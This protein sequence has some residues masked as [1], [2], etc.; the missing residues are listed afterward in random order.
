MSVIIL[1]K[2]TLGWRLSFL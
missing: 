1:A 2:T